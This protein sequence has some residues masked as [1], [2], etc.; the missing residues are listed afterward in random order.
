MIYITGI[1]GFVGSNVANTLNEQ[2]VLVSGCDNL[3][4]G[5]EKNISPEIY[6]EHKSFSEVDLSAFDTLVHCATSN[7]IYSQ[8][9]TVET[10]NN[11][12]LETIKLFERFKGKIIYTSTASVYNNAEVF[13]TPETSRVHVVNA[14]DTSKYISELYLKQRGNYTTLRLSN[15][16]GT[17]QHPNHPYSGAIGKMIGSALKGEP[18]KIYGD[19]KSTRDY[20][21]I[22]DTVEAI[23]KAIELPALNT[24]INVST[25]VETSANDLCKLIW[26]ILDKPCKYTREEPRSIDGITRRCLD[27]SK[28][29][30]LLSWSPQ[31]SLEEGIRR[32]IH[33]QKSQQMTDTID[34]AS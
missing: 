28:A 17:N 12:A 4:F 20:T 3:T 18:I 22:N 16:Y 34:I 21:Y 10:F 27:N 25:G 7:I 8:Q 5:Y 30:E 2:G 14:Y 31:V 19:G 23:I 11:N 13:P 24:E 29:K 32:T 15:V 1:C 26:K 6:W 9:N 33:W